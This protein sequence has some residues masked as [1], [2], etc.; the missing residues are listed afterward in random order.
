MGDMN[1]W[2]G[3]PFTN[4]LNVPQEEWSQALNEQWVEQGIQNGNSFTLSSPLNSTSFSNVNNP[5]GTSVF[6]DEFNQ[7]MNAGYQ[8]AD[9]GGGYNTLVPPSWP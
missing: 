3:T 7:L 9:G 5:G 8:G 4:V 1:G 2:E 6:F